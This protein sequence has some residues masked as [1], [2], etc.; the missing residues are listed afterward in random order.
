MRNARLEA[1]A[2]NDVAS[3]WQVLMRNLWEEMVLD[4]EIESNEEWTQH[5]RH[6]QVT[7]GLEL[8]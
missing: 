2:T 6:P 3:L 1:M 8:V 7:S 4:L 5:A